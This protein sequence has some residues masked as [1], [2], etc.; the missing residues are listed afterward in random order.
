MAQLSATARLLVVDDEPNMCRSLAILLREEGRYEVATAASGREALGKLD[1]IDLVITDLSMPGMDGLELLRKIKETAPE[2]QVVLMT[3]YSTVQS[4]VDA[5]KSGAFEYLLKP[6]AN[7]EL[8]AVCGQA[9]KLRRLQRENRRLRQQIDEGARFGELLGKSEPMRRLFHVIERAA[10]TD[11]TVLVRGESGTG[12]EL[13]ARAIHFQGHRKDGPFVALNCAA[14][15]PSILESELFG[16]EKGA[17]TGAVRTKLGKLEQ[18]ST[19]T[20]FLDE[21]GEMP[22][23][24]Q[25]KLL[26]ALQERAFERV[27][28]NETI[29][30][31]IRVIAATN[32]DLEKAVAEGSFREDLYYRLNVLAIDV[33]ALR[34]RMEDV[35]LLAES[36]LATKAEEMSARPKELSEAAHQA[37]AEYDFPGNVRELE[38]IIERAIVLADDDIIQPA[39]LPIRPKGPPVLQVTDLLGPSFKNGWAV[40]QSITKD[41]ERQLLTRALEAYGDRPNEEIARLLGTSRRVLELR[42]AEHGLRKRL[43]PR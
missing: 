25:T 3:A 30:V 40:L 33:P 11:A 5:M 16:H 35:P 22:A 29:R 43:P 19:G 42:L 1:R 8:L 13:V 39:D 2:T 23:G 21:I 28:G 32:R 7:E 31:D 6:F 26:R 15:T 9:L 10:E 24:L 20:L 37:L 18:A 36:F 34:D 17:F 27:G 38:N 4:A 12:K 41:L 14:L